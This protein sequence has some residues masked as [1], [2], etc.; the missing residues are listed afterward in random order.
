M[1]VTLDLTPTV[2]SGNTYRASAVQAA[3]KAYISSVAGSGKF[4]MSS[5]TYFSSFCL[6]GGINFHLVGTV[7]FDGAA[8]SV[9]ASGFC[10]KLQ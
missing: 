5:G 10:A 3:L 8:R 6:D 7:Q 9:G 2:L 4:T 1:L